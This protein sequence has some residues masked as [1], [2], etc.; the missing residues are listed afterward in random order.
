M[1]ARHSLLTT[2]LLTALLCARGASLAGPVPA[3]AA[4]HH[5]HLF[6]PAIAALLA[7]G[8]Q[9]LPASEVV[10]LMDAAGIGRAAVLSVAYMYG[11]PKRK[12]DDELAKVQAENDWHAAQAARYPGRL[13]A[14]CGVNPLKAYA[15]GELRRCAANRQ[16]G[17]MIKLH[18]GNSDV[19]VNDRVHLEKMRRFFRAANDHGMGLL[20][21]MRASIS[22]KRPYGAPEAQIFLEQLL[23]LVPD[24]PVQIAHMAGAGPGYDDPAADAVMAYLA[25]AAGQGDPRMRNVWFDVASLAA[26]DMAPANAATLVARMRR[27]GLARIVYGTDA[28]TGEN[29]RP[30]DAWAAFLK[31]PLTHD[32]FARIAGNV[33]PYLR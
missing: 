21:H 4:D 32:E 14:I 16:F 28:A 29:L 15:I 20:I 25:E 23:P 2:L 3:P 19:Q 5:Q 17:R 27:A 30:H 24:V 18:F 12:V 26:R 6:S 10:A 1:R 31:L 33:A 11:S 9:P 22:L 8:P 13:L 7:P